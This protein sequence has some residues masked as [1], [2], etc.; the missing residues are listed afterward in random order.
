MLIKFE[1]K[2]M[3]GQLIAGGEFNTVVEALNYRVDGLDR[4]RVGPRRTCSSSRQTA[5][6]LIHGVVYFWV[7]SVFFLSRCYEESNECAQA[8]V[9]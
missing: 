9:W 7:F 5:D 6:R 4:R 8:N 2:R 3:R 1:E